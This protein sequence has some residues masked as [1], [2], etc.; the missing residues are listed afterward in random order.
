MHQ[1]SNRFIVQDNKAVSFKKFK[2]GKPTYASP[3]PTMFMIV[4]KAS[5][6]FTQKRRAIVNNNQNKDYPSSAAGKA[7]KIVE[8]ECSI[9]IDPAI[10][11]TDSTGNFKVSYFS[12]LRKNDPFRFQYLIFC[13]K[14]QE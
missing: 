3:I 5:G 12:G 11:F 10:V 14:R 8:V 7:T 6:L 4:R 9:R 13:Q 1:G 2:Y